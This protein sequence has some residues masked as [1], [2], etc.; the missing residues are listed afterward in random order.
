MTEAKEWSEKIGEIFNVV[1]GRPVILFH[2]QISMPFLILHSEVDKFS[3][4]E[5][6]RQMEKRA[7]SWDKQLITFPDAGHNLVIYFCCQLFF[8]FLV[9]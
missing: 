7:V 8:M 1:Y 6:S 5:G 3:P 4:V 2:I 9:A